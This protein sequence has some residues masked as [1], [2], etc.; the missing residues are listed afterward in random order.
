MMCVD[1]PVTLDVTWWR[2]PSRFIRHIWRATIRAE[3][4]KLC[5]ATI[6]VPMHDDILLHVPLFSKFNARVASFQLRGL[7]REIAKDGAT[8]IQW[9][10][11]P[12]QGWVRFAFPNA[13]LIYECYDE[14]SFTPQG[15]P[16]SRVWA[17]EV[18]V[19]RAA[20]LT[21]VTATSLLKTRRQH[22]ER[23]HLIPNGI[24]DFFL[25]SPRQIDDQMDLIPHPRIGYVGV[26][27]VPMNMELLRAVFEHRPEWQL[28][29][30]GPVESDA[31][32]EKLADLPNVHVMGARP[33]EALPALM[34]KLD[35]GLIP[36]RI[37]RFSKGL[38]PLK[39]M[40]YLASGLPVVATRLPELVEMGQ[41]VTIAEDTPSDF[42]RAIDFALRIDRDEFQEAARALS[43][44]FTWDAIAERH[45][46]PALQ[47]V[48]SAGE[49]KVG[50]H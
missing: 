32:I 9:I 46:L 24:P 1:R 4:D 23:I 30:V 21:F 13:P 37:N 34:R 6:R 14:Y 25:N 38:R 44:H 26:I 7:I 33:F 19:L 48:L 20:A 49:G 40:E 5:V 39:L 35:V 18:S 45:I 31:G 41:F 28:V 27:R 22:S 12:E 42:E 36:H 50:G 47:S 16:R 43:S 29:L 2:H 15:D 17:L 8:A 3:S 11:R 10:Y